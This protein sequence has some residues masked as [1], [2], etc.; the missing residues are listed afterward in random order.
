MKPRPPSG[1]VLHCTSAGN[2]EELQGG[3]GEQRGR[4]LSL[5][6]KGG[7]DNRSPPRS[8]SL[9]AEHRL[10]SLRAPQ[11]QQGRL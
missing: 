9:A 2:G 10:L 3:G 6:V 5:A 1:F 7:L 8:L 11:Q 4:G